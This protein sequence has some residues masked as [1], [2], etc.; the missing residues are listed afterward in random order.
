MK[1]NLI[2]AVLVLIMGV[3]LVLFGTSVLAADD[4]YTELT[5]N[6]TTLDANMLSNT[7]IDANMLSNIDANALANTNLNGVNLSNISL[8]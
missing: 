7:N 4:G 5:L 1:T 8:K 6:N 2:K 3:T